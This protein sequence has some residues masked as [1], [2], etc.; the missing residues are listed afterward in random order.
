MWNVS[1][2]ESEKTDNNPVK[3]G[4]SNQVQNGESNQVGNDSHRETADSYDGAY[5]GYPILQWIGY[6]YNGRVLAEIVAL[7]MIPVR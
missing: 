5:V 3:N 6:W 1:R 2:I 7:G 4:E